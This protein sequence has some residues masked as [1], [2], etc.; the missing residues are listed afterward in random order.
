M[1]FML[2]WNFIL[3]PGSCKGKF[4]EVC[5]SVQLHKIFDLEKQVLKIFIKTTPLRVTFFYHTMYKHNDVHHTNITKLTA[6]QAPELSFEIQMN[7]NVTFLD[8]IPL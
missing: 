2:S 4:T 8:L 7:K 1:K 6:R 3:S 5:W